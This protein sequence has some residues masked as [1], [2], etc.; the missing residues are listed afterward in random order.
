MRLTIAHKLSLSA[1][2]LVLF[3]AGTVGGLFY[4]K[5]TALLVEQAVEDIGGDIRSAASRLQ[6]NIDAQRKDTLALSGTPPI[7]GMLRALN[8][9]EFDAQGGSSYQQWRQRLEAI[10]RTFLK[11]KPDYRQVRFIDKSGRERVVVLREDDKIIALND[12]QFQNKAHRSYVRDTLKLP[13][14]TVFLSEI[15]LNREHGV[16]SVPHQ[17]VLRSA[18]PVYS[19]LDES[20]AGLIIVNAEIGPALRKIQADIQDESV[21]IFITNDHGG[22]L[23][24]PE[25]RKAYGFDLGKRYRVQEDIPQLAPLYLPDNGE[26][27]SILLPADTGDSHVVSFTK[28]PF[29]PDRLNRFIAVGITVPYDHIVAKQTDVLSDVQNLAWVLVLVATAL[30]VFFSYRLS[31]PI[32]N[33]TQVM[34][35]YTHKRATKVAMPVN[36]NDEI[37]VLA[38]SYKNLID[39]VEEAQANLREMNQ[40]L[41]SMVDERTQALETSE[42]RQRSIIQSMADGLITI[43]EKGIVSMF[44]LAAEKIFGYQADEVI[45]QNVKMLMPEHFRFEHDDYLARYHQVG[46]G[47]G[48]VV[49][50]RREVE[51]QRKDGSSFPMD[52]SISE[53]TVNSQKVFIGGVRDITDRKL[54]D[55]LK[56]EFI[57]TVSHELRTPLTSIRG[58]LGLIN[59]GAMGELPEQTKELLVI[60][61]NNTERLLLLINDILD[62]QKIESGQITFSFRPLEIMS[63]VEQAII[64]NKAYGEQHGVEFV[65]R[66]RVADCN[67]MAD[68]DRL[69]QILSNLLSNAAKFSPKG[70]TVEINVARHAG[71]ILRISVTDHG[72]GIPEAFQPK[73]FDKFTQSD[74]S[75]TRQKGGTGLGLNITKALIE[76]HGGRIDFVSRKGFG[77]TFIV[78]LAELIDN[79]QDKGNAPRQLA[80]DRSSCVLI[81]ESDPD[82]AALE[83]RILAEA[84]FHSDIAA[85]IFQARK[86]I[87]EKADKLKVII[88]ASSLTGHDENSFL[89]EL[90]EAKETNNIPV[91]LVSAKIDDA[92]RDLNGAAIGVIDRLQK[93]IDP[94]RLIKLVKQFIS[95]DYRPRVLH[96]E[97]ERDVHTLVS[98]MLEKDCDL[99]WTTT[100]E[101]S[102]K[103]LEAEDFDLVLLDIGLPDGSGLDLLEII[104]QREIPPSVVIFSA[105]DVAQDYANKVSAVLEK[106]KTDNLKL[107][108][109]VN[110]VINQ[111]TT[112]DS[113]AP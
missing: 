101:D 82:I 46:D 83:Q 76:R 87:K 33:I 7:Q 52:V 56:N 98:M 66:N 8:A 44:N 5:T 29:D 96:V 97:D 35:D 78:E 80:G 103:M 2:L 54:I 86:K 14:G 77:T 89:D 31:L 26:S 61:G 91:V 111:R 93:P 23:L 3:S 68:R 36:K 41:E 30:A 51:G 72:P 22:F 48:N 39:Q 94:D 59:S 109:V 19:E 27:S 104:E 43:D 67:V 75:D 107:A 63:F 73:L 113:E 65:I 62:I 81:I 99:S 4:K 6:A 45:G 74:S 20:V 34:D 1:I 88:L 85:N 15:N 105:Y 42:I 17:E 100:F 110:Q 13:S 60:A 10:F 71:R 50:P 90:H 57:S 112:P 58:S 9:D 49:G 28:I 70:E 38:R 95:L 12:E 64:E 11:S 25:M 47:N 16:V 32:K 69:M 18:T 37:G 79:P 84:G 40:N 53:M 21:N 24:H 102:V 55:K 92:K 108:E 106:S